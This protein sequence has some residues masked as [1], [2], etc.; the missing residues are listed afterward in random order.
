L[1][2]AFLFIK[3]Q[4][5]F[6]NVLHLLVINIFNVLKL[7]KMKK[8]ILPIIAVIFVFSSCAKSPVACF[9]LPHT[10]PFKVGEVIQLDASCS[11]NTRYYSWYF[12]DGTF[13]NPSGDPKIAHTY[14]VAGT[15]QLKLKAEGKNSSESN[16]ELEVNVVQ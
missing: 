14:T 8:M 4:F 11:S 3:P 2:I 13:S 10:N 9:D 15:Y 16:V 5:S 6:F 1:A 12:K 7:N